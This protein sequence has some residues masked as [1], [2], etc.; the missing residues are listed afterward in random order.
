MESIFN[1]YKP[2]IV[3]HAAAYKHV[4]ILEYQPREAL[5]NNIQGTKVIID[6]AC[7]MQVEKFVLISTDKAVNP[8]N[9]LGVSKR[10][11]ELYT[12]SMNHKFK[13]QCITVRFG[14][15]LDSA[16]SVIPLFR[17]QIKHGGPVTVT[18]PD[19]TR[20]FMTINEATQLIMQA[21]SMGKGGE[22]FVLDMGEPVKIKYLAEQMIALSGKKPYKEIEISYCGLRPG[23]KLYEEL[24]YDAE[25]QLKTS[26][27]KI[28]LAKHGDAYTDASAEKIDIFI[29]EKLNITSDLLIEQMHEFLKSLDMRYQADKESAEKSHT[30]VD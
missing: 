19:I 14:N 24:F 17:E 25:N 6:T 9:I 26:H 16:G 21:A 3:F 2:E 4:P 28:F 12:E 20:Y 7:K 18:H 23:E 5:K 15:V 8:E 11:A 13:T 10:I 1:E 22:I 29:D 30:Q 27:E